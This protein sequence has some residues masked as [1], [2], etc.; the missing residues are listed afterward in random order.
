MLNGGK[1]CPAFRAEFGEPTP[2]ETK[3]QRILAVFNQRNDKLAQRVGPVVVVAV[4]FLLADPDA[5]FRIDE[6]TY[7]LLVLAAP[8]PLVDPADPRGLCKIQRCDFTFGI[9]YNL[10]GR[11][12]GALE[13]KVV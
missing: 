7:L 12:T 4:L 2:G 8:Q 10:A 3:K 6:E 11:G 9:A 1:R 5:G 13:R